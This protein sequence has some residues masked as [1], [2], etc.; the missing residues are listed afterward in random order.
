MI[1]TTVLLV[2]IP[3]L[4]GRFHPVLVH[5]PIGI[6]LLA[7]LFQLLSGKEKFQSLHAS[8]GIALFW[9]MLF[10]VASCISGYL[11]STTGD[12]DEDLIF[13]HQWI[14]IAVAATSII[15][16][17]LYRRGNKKNKWVMIVMVLLII[18]TGHLGGSITHGSDYL[19]AAFSSDSEEISA[20]KRKP[21]PDVQQAVAYSEVVK[22]ILESK[23]YGCH[24]PNKQKGK[25]RLDQPEFISK[26]GKDGKVIVEGKADESVLIKR[27]FLPKENKDHMPPKEKP[28]LSKQ[29]LE[30]L[31]WWVSSGADF[32]KKVNQLSQTG[33][34]KPVLLALQSAE[35][36]E[37]ITLSD[38]PEKLIDK[39]DPALI[40]KLKERGVA[41][42][43]VAQNSN[44]LS[45]NFVAVDSI[46]ENDL[47]LLESL[48]KQLISLKLGNS[49]IT[50]ANLTVIAKLLSL[51]RL[52]LERTS[53]TDKGIVQLKNLSQLQYLNLV[54]TKVTA[55]GL[56][57]LKELKN[58]QRI[59][60]YQT[61]IAGSEWDY[62]KKL[63]PKAILDTGGYKVP[64][65]PTDTVEV[66]APKTN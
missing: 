13:K 10:A 30:L 42:F 2:N 34:I 48:K 31:H 16:N 8:T 40:Q 19:T 17:Y 50:D 38:V 20:T 52:F 26:G 3:E 14:G 11:L 23:C 46:T 1:S 53:V 24:G 56:E 36:P 47:Q 21:I 5:L 57:P 60:L 62:L 54:G 51:T 15:A 29:D 32:T 58:L 45:A 43:P 44:Y 6:L 9:G 7:A 65:L 12:Y 49:K 22:P 41:I 63:F 4:I 66:K 39:A 27:V 18:I 33:K 25:L 59:F 64:S 28:Q 37:E 61:S 55:K 35:I